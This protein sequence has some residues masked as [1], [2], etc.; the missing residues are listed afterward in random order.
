METQVLPLYVRVCNA[1]KQQQMDVVARLLHEE[2]GDIVGSD[3][4]RRQGEEFNYKFD[5]IESSLF[6]LAFAYQCPLQLFRRMIE[7]TIEAQGPDWCPTPHVMSYMVNHAMYHRDIEYTKLRLML[8]VPNRM[9]EDV[10]YTLNQFSGV[11]QRENATKLE[12]DNMVAFF[13]WLHQGRVNLNAMYPC[14]IYLPDLLHPGLSLVSHGQLIK[15][16]ATFLGMVLCNWIARPHISGVRLDLYTAKYVQNICYFMEQLL[17]RI[18]ELRADVEF[19]ADMNRHQLSLDSFRKWILHSPNCTI[20]YFP[21]TKQVF[22]RYMFD[23]DLIV[24]RQLPETQPELMLPG[25]WNFWS[26]YVRIAHI[27]RLIQIGPV[28]PIIQAVEIR[29]IALQSPFLGVPKELMRNLASM[30]T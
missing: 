11:L 24:S 15:V 16:R 27:L 30:F 6:K 28:L 12:M 14:G 9:H 25:Q 20:A 18:P 2:A 29:R 26:N 21:G 23:G 5:Y 1:V 17:L 8:E 3:D 13:V 10:M 7:R 22:R 4:E 19:P